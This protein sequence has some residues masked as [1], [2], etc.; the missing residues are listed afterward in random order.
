MADINL[1]CSS[2]PLTLHHCQT[3]SSS[4]RKLWNNN[5]AGSNPAFVQTTET[6][7]IVQVRTVQL[8]YYAA[9]CKR[10]MG[11]LVG[12][13]F[14]SWSCWSSAVVEAVGMDFDSIFVTGL[15]KRYPPID[16]L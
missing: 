6:R 1:I 12:W 13:L 5:P 15:S 11:K 3:I 10:K 7:G 2:Q 4:Q 14:S 16:F 9:I 8:L